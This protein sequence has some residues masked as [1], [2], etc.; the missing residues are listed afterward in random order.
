[1]KLWIPWWNLIQG[2][3][4]SCSRQRT[5]FWLCIVLIGFIIRP[6]MLGVTS[7]IR[8]IGLLPCYYDRLLDFFHSPSVNIQQ[9]TR[10][11]VRIV[12][13]K[14]PLVR[15]NDR[16]VLVGD[17]LK[18]AKSGKK[19]PGVKKL[20]QE[21][22]SNTKPEYILGHSCQAVSLLAGTAASVFSIPLIARIH[23]GIQCSN[24]DR[25]T[26]M[27]KMNA[28]VM[29][30]TIEQPFYLLADAYYSNRRIIRSLLKN[31]NHLISR[32]R[33][34]AVA[35]EQALP[36]QHGQRGAPRKYGAKVYLR[37]LFNNTDMMET[38]YSPVYGE[39]QVLL[40]YRCRD[41]VWKSGG[42]VRFV[43]VAHPHRGH[44]LLMS[45]DTS[46]SPLQ[47]IELYGYRFK[48]EVSFKQALRTV[49]AFAYHFWMSAMKPITRKGKTQYLHRES[50]EYRAQVQRKI[51]A[52]HRFIQIGL[53]A[54]GSL[55]YLS[56]CYSE[57]VW[58]HFGSWIRTIRPEVLPS[59]MVTMMAMKNTVVE[60][61][62]GTAKTNTII[63]FIMQKIDVARTEGARFA[64]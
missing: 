54:Q 30:L 49:G 53:I 23:Q 19:M 24:R 26:L 57:L 37:D 62:N 28:L 63:K 52:Y 5:F 64:A 45:T 33:S 35:Y 29:T 44:V 51:D 50:D 61:F 16:I 31:G 25:R 48:I 60:F 58:K 46:L 7:I 17:G 1:M 4:P 9:L 13:K 18:V 36:A 42:I 3:R 20:H 32:V 40:Q 15:Y 27:D 56:C 47:I 21:S 55:Q 6:D 59:E 22:E 11:W 34:T 39:K 10:Y 12:I 8:A 2:L 41:L 38:A 14:F 43:A